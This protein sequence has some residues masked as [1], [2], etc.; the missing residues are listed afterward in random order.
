MQVIIARDSL[1]DLSGLNEQASRDAYRD[2]LEEQIAVEYGGRLAS[3]KVEY[4][5]LAGGL[6]VWPDGDPLG[7]DEDYTVTAER[8][9]EMAERVF[10]AMAGEWM[11]TA[12]RHLCRSCARTIEEGDFDC[13]RNADHDWALC[14]D[15]AALGGED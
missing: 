4:G 6:Q 14:D 11:I 8:V 2:L 13:E 5:D 12:H 3:L 9:G 7:D 10:S 15:C 1:G